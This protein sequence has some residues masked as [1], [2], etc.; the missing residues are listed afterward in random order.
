MYTERLEPITLINGVAAKKNYRSEKNVMLETM[1]R[2]T[3]KSVNA[4]LILFPNPVLK[5]FHG[6]KSGTGHSSV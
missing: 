2:K 4:F 6:P 3:W 1:I 5:I